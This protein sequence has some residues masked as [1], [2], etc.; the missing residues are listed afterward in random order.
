MKTR[1][2]TLIVGLV[3]ASSISFVVLW[4]ALEECDEQCELEKRR[5][6]AGRPNIGV[7]ELPKKQEPV[8][9]ITVMRPNSMEFFYYPNPEDTENRDVFQKFILIRLP[10]ALGGTVDDVSAF[11]AYSALSV[12]V[13]C[14]IKYW[15]DDGRQRMEDP[16]WGSMYRPTDGAMM[17]P[18]PVMNDSPLG[19]PYLDLSIDEN[20]S[21]YVEPPVWTMQENGVI[22]VGRIM[23]MQEI[24]QGS[25]ILIDS[26]KKTNP[27]HPMIPV[28][29]AGLVLAEIHPDHNNVNAR[30]TDF[31]SSSYQNISF[32][33]RNVSAQ[34]QKS[35]LNV[36][37]PNSEFWQINDT[38]IRIGGSAMDKNSSLPESFRDYN[39]E[40]ILD[41][42]TFVITGPDLNSIKT[43]IVSNYFPENN[44][45]DLFL[46]SSTVME[47]EN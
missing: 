16:C 27:N 8:E 41:G 7:L 36:A 18:Y 22:G 21:L 4:N 11:R 40:F 12:G 31:A 2:L 25:Q 10:E 26:Y 42:F 9:D 14:Q 19:L 30:Y 32:E 17:Y 5:I 6:E 45:D 35:F 29:F 33:V 43:S 24:R 23:S 28:D 13:H 37:K 38:I 46:V 1:F 44:Y 15:P 47:N 39:V 3:I 20:G 34:D